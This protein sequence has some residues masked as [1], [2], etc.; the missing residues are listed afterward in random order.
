MSC[1]FL[2]AVIMLLSL[3]NFNLVVP[4]N[5]FSIFS[6][7]SFTKV[8]QDS[9][10]THTLKCTHIYMHHYLHS[11]SNIH[12][13]EAL[14]RL[15]H[16]PFPRCPVAVEAHPANYCQARRSLLFHNDYVKIDRIVSCFST[17]RVYIY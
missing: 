8:L 14:P 1:R 3:R 4:L 16:F 15:H 9:T 10:H 12:A 6:C 17:S 5:V 11:G 13:P 7:F 2:G